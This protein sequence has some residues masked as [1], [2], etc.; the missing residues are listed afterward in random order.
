MPARVCAGPCQ[1]QG[2]GSGRSTGRLEA[3]SVPAHADRGLRTTPRM[4]STIL[5]VA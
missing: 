1:R 3:A 4:L 5:S 2:G